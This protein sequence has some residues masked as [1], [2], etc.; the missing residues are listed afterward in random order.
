MK[1]KTFFTGV[2]VGIVA[3]I[4][5]AIATT[6]QSGKQLRRNIVQNAN[7][8]KEQLDDVKY[9][10]LNVKQSIVTATNEAKNNIPLI[11]NEL[12]EAITNFK[13]EIEPDALKLQQEIEALQKSISEIENNLPE[14]K[15][16]EVIEE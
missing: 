13:Q 11:I 4:V 12:S 14:P 10:L 1:A 5:A 3:G 7:I 16:Q 6:P 8:A 15:K 2:T 9:E